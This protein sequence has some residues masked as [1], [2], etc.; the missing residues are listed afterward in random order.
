MKISKIIFLTTSLF[1]FVIDLISSPLSNEIN[2]FKL[3][4]ENAELVDNYFAYENTHPILSIEYSKGLTKMIDA[5]IELAYGEYLEFFAERE[6]NRC[7]LTSNN[8]TNSIGINIISTFH[9]L[10][11]FE[12]APHW[13]DCYLLAKTGVIHFN[14]TR[15]E[16]IIPQRGSKYNASVMVGSSIY[17][18]NSV[19]FN[20]EYGLNYQKYYFGPSLKYGIIVRF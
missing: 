20:I 2:Y 7:T 6:G 15:D 14:S 4:F 12:K 1:L 13:F 17:P 16:K 5:G 19:G 11:L 18:F 9:V 3:N 10:G 8:S